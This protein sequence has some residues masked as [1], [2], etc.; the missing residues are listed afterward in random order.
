MDFPT[1][2]PNRVQISRR[3][4]SGK[5]GLCATCALHRMA[6]CAGRRE[7]YAHC[8][9]TIG[10][11]ERHGTPGPPVPGM[12]VG[13]RT[14]E[15]EMG[16]D[17]KNA[18]VASSPARKSGCSVGQSQKN[19][20]LTHLFV[21]PLICLEGLAGSERVA[22]QTLASWVVAPAS[23]TCCSQALVLTGTHGDNCSSQLGSRAW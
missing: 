22:A 13:D 11:A 20:P 1:A 23:R 6:Q 15:P 19:H 17:A 21:A 2:A 3:E 5:R 18:A 12:H 14:R 10:R 4:A 16:S 9:P 7:G 8:S